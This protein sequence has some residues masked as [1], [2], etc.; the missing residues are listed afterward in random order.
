MTCRENI[1]VTEGMAE[2]YG[3]TMMRMNQGRGAQ[4]RY[5]MRDEEKED[6]QQDAMEVG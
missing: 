4:Y 1:C 3:S 2:K 5:R 6:D